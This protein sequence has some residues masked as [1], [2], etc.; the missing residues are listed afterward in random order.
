[1]ILTVGL[2]VAIKMSGRWAQI[3]NARREA[4]KAELK[5]S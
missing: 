5:L 4:E 1:M 3:E 2:S